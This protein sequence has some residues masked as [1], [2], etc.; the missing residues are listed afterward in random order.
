MKSIK[1]IIVALLVLNMLF[2]GSPKIAMADTKEYYAQYSGSTTASWGY[3]PDCT[4]TITKI[5][6]NRFKG[7]FSAQNIDKYSFTQNITGTVT[8]SSESF[9]CFFSV[10]FYNNRY[11]SNIIATVYPYEG[12]CECF[13]EGSWHLVDFI[14]NGTKFSNKIDPNKVIE[15]SNYNED[16]MILSMK[17]SNYIYG[18][19]ETVTKK[20]GKQE[21]KNVVISYDKSFVN[22]IKKTDTNFIDENNFLESSIKVYNFKHLGVTDHDADNVAFAIMLRETDKKSADV[23]VVIRGTYKD[24]W[25]GNTEIT[26]TEYD[27]SCK[28]HENFHKASD[29]IKSTV[30][31]YVKQYCLDYDTVNLI[32]TGHSRGA[33]VANLY[34]KEATD[35]I[36]GVYDDSIP[37]FSSVTAYTFATP[38]AA[39]YD[40]SMENYNNIYN[41]CFK[42]DVVPTVPLIKPVS[43]WGY[44]KYGKTFFASLNDIKSEINLPTD[45]FYIVNNV[46]KI[47]DCLLNWTS[48]DDYYNKKLYSKDSSKDYTTL[49]DFAHS[50]TGFFGSFSKK[51]TGAY[52]LLKDYKK[53]GDIYPIL[54]T[55]IPIIGSI[56]NAHHYD[57][58][59]TVIENTGDD[60]FKQ[61]SFNDISLSLYSYYKVQNDINGSSAI[62]TLS[63]LN[64]SN[65]SQL[66]S[67]ANQGDN[68]SVLGWSLDDP[69]T[70]TGVTWNDDGIV[71]SID[72][73]YKNLDGNLDLSN[74]SSLKSL[75]LSGNNLT[76]VNLDNCSSLE[77]FDCS[78]N[79]L[80]SL[81]LSDCTNLKSV[82][83]CYNYLDTHEGST[84]YN[85]LDDL[86]FSDCYV[87]YYPQSVPDNAVFNTT[88]LNALKTFAKANGNNSTLD[89]LDSKG[90]IDTE[91]LQNNVLFE[92]DGSKYRVV[93]IDISDLNVSGTLNLTSLSLLQELYC[94]NTK[95]TTLNVKNCTKL[96]TLK[97]DGCE[98][99][100]VTLP[101]NA[102][103][104]TSS[105]YDVSC[106]Y[107]YL[108]TSIFTQDVIKYIEFKAGGKIQY[109]NQ[110]GDSSAMQAAL[111][112]ANKLDEK[113]YSTETFEPFK[114][115]ID[116]CN[117]YNYDNLYLTQDDIDEITTNILVAM[118][119]LKAYFNVNISS[120]NGSFTVNDENAG[121]SYKKSLLYGTT[122]TVNAVSNEGYNF[123]GWY[124]EINNRYLSKEAQYTFM[125]SSNL[126]LKA[127]IVPDGSATLTF[128][129]YSNWV[130][131]EVTKTTAQWAQINSISDF[132]PEVPYRYGYSDG[133][134]I[135][136]EQEILT[137]LK[138]GENVLITAEYIPGDT[139]LPTP[140][141]AND[142]PLLDL[143]YKYDNDNKVGSFVMAAGFPEN[144][145][146]ESVGVAF[147]YK[148]ADEFD[149]TDNFI[150]LMNN[151]MLVS[152][153]NT[154]TLEDIYIVNINKMSS[155]YNWVARGY[156]TYYD[157]TGKP[158]TAY[159]NQIN[160]IDTKNADEMN[161]LL[162]NDGQSINNNPKPNIEYGNGEDD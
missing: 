129:N 46:Y 135:Y 22:I 31:K 7:T 84:L 144:I 102:K 148:N 61:V 149:P 154:D 20:N 11:Y 54:G 123:V 98:L 99:T 18:Y 143:Y 37:S 62:I 50:A 8:K 4:F 88:E 138:S 5:A 158:V 3:K 72:L 80:T 122:V 101:S 156:V 87:N 14:M 104:K 127:I 141:E 45:D 94:E 49:Y 66:T 76:S 56:G 111:Y 103:A 78:F 1:R 152:R 117:A 120:Q 110:K 41:F 81:D 23:F 51:V 17:L 139:T 10:N 28:V 128:A 116:E 12:K 114:E 162:E 125:V 100:S 30:K 83:C 92:Y 134:W 21:E 146:I 29:S 132:L 142:V 64:S 74:F 79:K 36:N 89:W 44:W 112:F 133:K 2:I 16:D 33:A 25:Q 151:K 85:A 69:S 95:I 75:N 113:D 38:N 107:N 105:L 82:I 145:K 63:D 35:S 59:L 137:K 159:S 70:W 65:I 73:S 24:E 40:N 68:L 55:A 96:E 97:C 119:N 6:G 140:R 118:Y 121:N 106:E 34:A 60:Y 86:M 15:L 109:K 53:Y 32:V 160:I 161:T 52:N 115:L 43:G 147:Y 9:T 90:N 126:K 19:K 71:E 130:A 13:C 124:D 108:D 26:G 91:K 93:A 136:D 27:A 157:E 47:H 57:T 155:K 150:L 58:Y 42:E 39:K 48:V 67:F 153:F 77:E 131:G